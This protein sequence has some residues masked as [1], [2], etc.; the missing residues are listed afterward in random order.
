MTSTFT[1]SVA[2]V[3]ANKRRAL[4]KKYLFF[5]AHHPGTHARLRSREMLKSFAL[6]RKQPAILILKKKENFGK[7]QSWLGGMK[8]KPNIMKT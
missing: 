2:S 6:K 4:R 5:I 7:G 3:A 8:C 1:S